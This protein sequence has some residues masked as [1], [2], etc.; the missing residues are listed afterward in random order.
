MQADHKRLS[1]QTSSGGVAGPIASGTITTS[2][3]L[4]AKRKRHVDDDIDVVFKASLGKR[5]KKG[6]LR[7][8]ITFHATRLMSSNPTDR[9]E[10]E[11]STDRNLQDVLGAIRGAPTDN[12]RRRKGNQHEKAVPT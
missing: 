9:R 7:P 5:V 2:P 4:T 11:R 8:D 1:D 6:S 10:P 12:K 3:Q